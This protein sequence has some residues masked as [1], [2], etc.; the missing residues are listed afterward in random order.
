MNLL[1][2]ITDG[3]FGHPEK[4]INLK[5]TNSHFLQGSGA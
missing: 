1:D 4:L 2:T 3:G 5:H